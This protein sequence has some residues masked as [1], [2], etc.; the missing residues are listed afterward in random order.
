MLTRFERA[1]RKRKSEGVFVPSLTTDALPLRPSSSKAARPLADAAK[2]R[3][4]D[5]EEDCCIELPP[6]RTYE[7]LHTIFSRP[8]RSDG[9]ASGEGDSI[10]EKKCVAWKGG[11]EGL[12]C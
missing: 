2:F 11:R 12:R 7:H 8:D 5:K 9:S 1:S 4:N 10:K 3:M 6:L